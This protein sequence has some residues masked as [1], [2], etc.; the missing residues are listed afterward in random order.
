ML[1]EVAGRHAG[2]S[3]LQHQDAHAL[4]GEL[5]GY[6][7]TT[8]AGADNYR[9]KEL[10]AGRHRRMRMVSLRGKRQLQ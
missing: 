3:G 6:P 8:G 5:L 2:W 9:V 1:G 7:A 10:F 4:L